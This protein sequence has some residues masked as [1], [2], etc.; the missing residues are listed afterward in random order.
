MSKPTTPLWSAMPSVP[1]RLVAAALTLALISI[2]APWLHSVV[3]PALGQLPELGL[4]ALASLGLLA[5][6]TLRT[7]SHH[8]H[9]Y[10]TRPGSR[11]QAARQD[12]P[13]AH[14]VQEVR[15]MD[16][17]LHLMDQQLADAVNEY[18]QVA[19]QVIGRMSSIH[20]VSIEQFERIRTTESNSEELMRTMK[21][22]SMVDTQL[23]SILQMFVESQ[24]QDVQKNLERI[25]RLQGV[26]GLVPLV[27]VIAQVARQTNFL[28]INA[29]IEAARAGESGRSFAVLAAE[30]RELSHRTAEAASA[31]GEQIRIATEGI[32]QEL[33]D[34]TQAS[35][36]QTTTSNMRKVI[37]DIAEMQSRFT[38]SMTQLQL[39]Q[40][41]TEIKT[42]H[43]E[44]EDQL[45]DALG[46][47]Q[48]QDVMRQRVECVQLALN[49]LNEHLQ[50][51]ANELH[52]RSWHP[53]SGL[54]MKARMD[55]Q[56]HHY[57]MQAQRLTHAAVA[58]QPRSVASSEPAIELF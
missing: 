50:G 26:S 3:W 6:W 37:A 20:E 48:V 8:L 28:A 15:D 42:G 2:G 39:H 10:I 57:V 23:G 29:A 43:Q 19:L 25:K 12:M 5:N 46:Q 54:S 14:L 17:Y 55:A 35:E 58:G 21:E 53:E 18:E 9:R 24:E 30:I 34:A 11:W 51:M 4:P 56:H 41:I 16:P 49:G 36:R 52:D 31:I 1:V 40:V 22:K 44:I 47:M 13:R 38:N 32:D 33:V 27:D 45:T 7:L